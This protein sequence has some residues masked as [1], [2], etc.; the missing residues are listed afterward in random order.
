MLVAI[1]LIAV[2][3]FSLAYVVYGR[4]LANRY[5]LDD[6]RPTPSH[7]DYDGI[8]RIPAHKAVLLG[9]HFSSIAGAAPIVGPIIAALAFGWLPVVIW[10]ILGTIFIGGVIDFSALVASIRHNA[11]SIAEI[12]RKYVSPLAYRLLLAFI[13]LTLVYVL[14]V[15]A[16][17]T[18]TTFADDGGVASS[19]LM[20]IALAVLFGLALNKMKI[21]LLWASAVFVPLVFLAVWAGQKVPISASLIPEI[22]AGEPKKTWAVILILYCFVAS[23]TPVWIL[24]QPRDYLSSYLL[25]ASV[26]SGFVGIVIGGFTIQYPAFTTWS[27]PQ[28][29]TLFPILFI[30]VACGACSGFHS[31][32]ASGTSSKQLN[33]ETDSRAIGYGGMLLEGVVAVIALATVAMLPKG[34]PLT[35]KAPLAIYGSGIANFLS[36][37]GVPEKLGFSFGL[38]A[39]SAFI[40]TT[41]DTATRLG[42]YIF[43]ELFNLKGAH[44][45][46]FSTLATLVLPT[47]FVLI[48][49]KDAQ[50][51][52]IPAWKAIW[53]VFGT[54][55]QL[56]A[57]LVA[58]VIAVWLRKTGKKVGFIL[59]PLFFMNI[60]TVWALVLLVRQHDMSSAVRVIAA[61]LLLLAL[62]LI[63]EVGRTIR[64][65]VVA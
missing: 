15:F 41:L 33:K 14:T 48:N 39:L 23:T 24:L 59:G 32:V 60:V 12:A 1:L 34:D 11:R 63:V 18:A 4:F 29:G 64:K 57:G 46:Y 53:P 37:L 49:L 56:L 43:E 54:C 21:P 27:V 47:V 52:L 58:L 40:L 19:S 8:D 44:S 55:N 35:M 3:G 50:G 30:T 5:E 31:I 10:I 26:L 28:T 51:N 65:V 6:N 13:W 62:V 2:A 20:F 36:V 38:L 9:H 25:Y 16:D 61:V 45:R 22:V 7:T 17:L 42:R